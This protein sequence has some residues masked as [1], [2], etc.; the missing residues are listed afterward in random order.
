MDELL[1][2]LGL[3]LNVVV[4]LLFFMASVYLTL[5]MTLARLISAPQ[6]PVLW[7]FSV[8]T[9]PLTR[10]IRALLPPA[11]PEGRVRTIAL[12]VYVGLWLLSRGVL[13]WL[14]GGRS[15]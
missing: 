4:P 9:G 11:T 12:G 14:L 6:S 2:R 15:G 8:V 13:V 3:V 1:L 7:F 10:P 5:H